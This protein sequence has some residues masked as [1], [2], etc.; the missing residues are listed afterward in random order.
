MAPAINQLAGPSLL[1]R[2]QELNVACWNVR[3]LLN[4]GSQCLTM[5][6][7]H[8]YQIDIACLSEVRLPSNGCRRIKIPEHD[9][10]YTLYHSGP[11][12]H[13]GIHGVAIALS[14]RASRSLLTWK[15]INQRLAY[16]RLSGK[17]F[18]ISIIAVY[19]PT[20]AADDAEKYNFYDQL[21]QLTDEV[22]RRD[23]LLVAGDWNAKTGPSDAETRHIIGRYG[24]GVRCNNGDRLLQFADLNHMVVTNTRFQHRRKH[25]L[26]WYSNDG[27]TASQIDYVLI[28]A[29]WASCVLDCR[30]YRGAD[31]GT[32]HGSDHVMVRAR[33]RLRLTTRKKS[34]ACKRFNTD[35]LKN[36]ST[37]NRLDHA[38]HEKLSATLDPAP[39]SSI[40]HRWT[41]FKQAVSSATLEN[42]G[43]T[44]RKR[45]DWISRETIELSDAAARARLMKSSDYANLRRQATRSVRAD[46]NRYWDG[47]AAEMEKAAAIGDTRKLYRTLRAARCKRS[48]VSQLIRT[49]T[50]EVVT[51]LSDRLECWKLHFEQALNHPAPPVRLSLPAPITNNYDVNCEPPTIEEV[52]QAINTLKNS[53]APGEDN[54]PAEIYKLCSKSILQPLTLLFGEI[55]SSETFPEDWSDALLLPFYKKGDKSLCSNY[56]GISLID[57][58]AKIFAVVL[59]RRFRQQRE[60]RTRPN[61]AGFRSGKGCIDQIFCIRRIL[62]HRW[63][64]QQ[65]T[66]VCFID[67][68]AAFDSVDRFSLWQIMKADGVPEK[69][70]RLLR[71]YYLNTKA[72]VR[73]YGETSHHFTVRTGVRQGCVLS[74]ILFNFL[75]DWV[76]SNALSESQG[77]EIT[78]NYA[79]TDL[80]YAD[81]IA[82]FATDF[83]KMQLLVCSIAKYAESVGLKI[84]PRKTQVMCANIREED[85]LT[86]FIDGLPLEEVNHFKYLGSGILPTG[87]A[88]ADISARI[89][90]ARA[91]FSQLYK[92]LWR[93]RD[94]RLQTKSRIYHAVVRSVLLY[95]C[96]AWQLRVED[97]RRLQVFEHSCLRRILGVRLTDRLR[98]EELRRRCGL[99]TLSATV[100]ERRLRWFGHALRK[101]A[102][103]LVAICLRAEPC[104]GWKRRRGGQLKT[105]MA[106]VKEDVEKLTGPMIYGRQRWG[107]DWLRII[108][109]MAQDRGRW[110]AFT[111]DII[112]AG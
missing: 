107:Q 47:I 73:V 21:Q 61:Q 67:F 80:D 24:L 91:V 17:L 106:T 81:D 26:T 86:I 87:Q 90:L 102:N 33:L 32:L 1:H 39:P 36:M 89:N 70:I 56:R 28:K 14:D 104:P 42:V 52:H 63:C 93:R 35:E 38:L 98:N 25:L 85:K 100:Q 108:S 101:N 105:W 69:L 76:L 50:G 72:R 51:N 75:I 18:N 11:T 19:A 84:N 23:M 2:T 53:K 74:P 49:T 31:T 54:I 71:A 27:R 111:R 62:E 83:Q 30:S 57:V 96:E 20:L 8:R 99:S 43:T 68:A 95:G 55:W 40:D 12:D 7:L 66:V 82:V 3:T 78:P 59:L 46:R 103:D 10:F 41:S 92:A 5:R 112:E 9:G 6:T 4:T 79:V 109:D 16:I 77:V 97:L 94:V 110:R 60:L 13:S 45:K 22:S 29:R 64:Y 65:P 37:V 15:P 44:R 58:A 34:Q 88:H 48:E